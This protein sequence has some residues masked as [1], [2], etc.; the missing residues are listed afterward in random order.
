MPGSSDN[1]AK[2]SIAVIFKECK[3]C[4]TGSEMK[5]N[6]P[7]CDL[8]LCKRVVNNAENHAKGQG[9]LE[10]FRELKCMEDPEPFRKFIFAF[11]RATGGGVPGKGNR[12]S[13]TFDIARYT[14]A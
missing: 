7:Y 3:L 5:R 8:N 10:F 11:K 6:Q 12:Q 4:L 1:Q 2:K 9:E 13:G 14:G